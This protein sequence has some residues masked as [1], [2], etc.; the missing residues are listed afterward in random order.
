MEL[1][2]ADSRVTLDAAHGGAIRE[3]SWQGIAILRPAASDVASD[4]FSLACFPLV[5]YANRVAGGRFEFAG[6]Q[7]QLARNWDQD[8][9]PIHGQGWRA[10]WLAEQLSASAARLTFQG[11][12]DDWPWPYRA[13]QE[14]AVFADGLQI[15]LAVENQSASVMPAMLGIHPYF[16]APA[17]ASIQARTRTVWLT[18]AQALPVQEVLAPPD[19]SFDRPRGV[20]RVALDHCFDHW[21]GHASL[22]WPD[23]IL[24][25]TSAGC[26]SLHVYTP[27]GADFFCLEPQS[28]P[29]GALNRPLGEVARL[30]PGACAQM[31]V[32]FSLARP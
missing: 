27:V 21:D 20:A 17:L 8:P 32:R 14:F 7:V 15:R 10:S 25:L 9:Y 19:W 16:P 26:R 13:V 22:R 2:N 24:T 6:R 11:G 4:P 30:A 5:P 31:S 18:D 3:F 28:A 23:R 12:G 29:A 1:R